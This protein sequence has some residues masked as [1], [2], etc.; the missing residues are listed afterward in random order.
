LTVR[1]GRWAVYACV[2]LEALKRAEERNEESVDR[3]KELTGLV[4][5]T[6]IEALGI[7]VV[8]AEPDV[9]VMT[10]PVTD[11]TRQPFGLLH[12]GA[13]VALAESA[14]SMGTWLNCD[15]SRE[16]AVGIEINAN[17][18]RA[19]QDGIVTATA[20]PLHRGRRT[21]VWDIRITDEEQRLICV[22]RCTV[23]VVPVEPPAAAAR[24]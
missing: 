18:I 2:C 3:G 20:T 12:G 13:S 1:D 17:H 6:M 10:M 23:A 15:P 19:K 9:I 21:M 14:A 11:V 24:P 8:R 5:G 16:R 7:E 4:A 22:S